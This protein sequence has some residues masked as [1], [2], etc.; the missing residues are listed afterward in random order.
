MVGPKGVSKETTRNWC[1][2]TPLLGKS[3]TVL[4]VTLADKPT[5]QARPVQKVN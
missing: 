5:R 1:D 4:R 3:D 2:L